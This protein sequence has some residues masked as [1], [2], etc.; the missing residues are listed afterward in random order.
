[1]V[2]VFRHIEGLGKCNVFFYL[3]RCWTT[4]LGVR[5]GIW[6]YNNNNNWRTCDAVIR[7]SV[8]FSVL[9]IECVQVR[10]MT[11]WGLLLTPLHH[12]DIIV[13]STLDDEFDQNMNGVYSVWTWYF[14]GFAFEQY[15]Q[16]VTLLDG[17]ACLLDRPS[18]PQQRVLA[19]WASDKG[20]ITTLCELCSMIPL[21]FISPTLFEIIR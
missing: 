13:A 14:V 21:V 18:E 7:G 9:F 11:D 15:K 4:S 10:R 8:L 17:V 16:H 1:M 20:E 6:T 12:C 19:A 3:S 2:N 5:H